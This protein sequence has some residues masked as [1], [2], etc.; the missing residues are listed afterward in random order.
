MF[1]SVGWGE[2]LVLLVVGLLVIGPE[3]LPGLINEARAVLLAIRNAVGEAKEQLDGEF[4]DELKQFSKPISEL[5]SVRQMGARG[6]ITK[7]LLDGDDSFLTS[8]DSTKNDVK[9][10]V[11]GVRKTNLRDALCSPQNSSSDG[12]VPVQQQAA[13]GESQAADRPIQSAAQ[14]MTQDLSSAEG[15]GRIAGNWDDVT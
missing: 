3:R 12:A 5:N 6:F 9:S 4:G 10:T 15:Q 1:S 2:V 14:D 11:D 13:A 8:F 7:T